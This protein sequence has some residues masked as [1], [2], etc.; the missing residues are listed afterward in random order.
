MDN[1]NK[2]YTDHSH[3]NQDKLISR[4]RL[5]ERWGVSAMT[6]KRKEKEGQLPVI[7]FNERLVRYRLSDVIAIE[8]E[9]ITESNPD[10]V[11]SKY[12]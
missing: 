7:R 2:R 3:E 11:W 9:N 1:T 12:S 6:I 10:N 5:A 8:R 4:A